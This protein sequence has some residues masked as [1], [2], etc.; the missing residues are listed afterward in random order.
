VIL[1]HEGFGTV[2]IKPTSLLEDRGKTFTPLRPTDCCGHVRV[3]G[4]NSRFGRRRRERG[5]D[6][7]SGV[8]VSAVCPVVNPSIASI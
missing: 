1:V 8:G 2:R 7:L 5:R 3:P 6:H 4:T